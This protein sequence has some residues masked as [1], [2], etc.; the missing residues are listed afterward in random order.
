MC[1]WPLTRD[2]RCRDTGMKSYSR[3]FE[4]ASPAQVPRR[5]LTGPISMLAF[6]SPRTTRR[7][8]H[9]P[10]LCRCAQGQFRHHLLPAPRQ[11]SRRLAVALREPGHAAL[12]FYC[13]WSRG[14][15]RQEPKPAS[16]G[17]RPKSLLHRRPWHWIDKPDTSAGS[18]HAT[19]QVD[20]AII[21][22]S[23]AAGRDWRTCGNLTL[24]WPR[25]TSACAAPQNRR[26]LGP[27]DVAWQI[28]PRRL[29][30]LLGLA[31]ALCTARRQTLLALIRESPDTLRIADLCD[32]PARSFEWNACR[33][34]GFVGHPAETD[35]WFGRGTLHSTF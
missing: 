2:G 17:R 25:R 23:A 3:L 27:A 33:S 35:E 21:R 26:R 31:E 16:A 20:R 34:Q 10:A 24:F 22:Q 11:D 12:S 14:I 28:T 9:D 29:N 13:G 19:A 15:G 1:R 18:Q 4:R 30:A 8:R 32:T 6:G 5:N 7:R